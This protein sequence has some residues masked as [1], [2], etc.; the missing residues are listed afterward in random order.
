MSGAVI[1]AVYYQR[2]RRAEVK[3]GVS[4]RRSTAANFSTHDGVIRMTGGALRHRRVLSALSAVAIGALVAAAVAWAW[5]VV[6]R[7][8]EDPLEKVQFTHVEVVQGEVGSSA[9]FSTVAEWTPIQAGVNRA[10]GVVTDEGVAAGTEVTQGSTLY[11]VDLRPIVIGSGLVPMFRDVGANMSGADVKQVQ[12]LLT[13]LGFY[14]GPVTGEAGTG[15]ARSIRAWQKSLRVEQTGVVKAG[16]VIFVQTLPTRV[17]LDT[18]LIFRGAS[19]VAGE[20]VLSVLSASPTF[21]ISVTGAQASMMPAGTRVEVIAPEGDIWEGVTGEQVRDEQAGVVKVRLTGQD[22]SPV[23]RDQCH[24]VPV[25]GQVSLTAR[26]V[27]TETV[28]GLVVPSS[29]LVSGA[30]GQLAVIN[31]QGMRQSVELIAS[32][33]G[34]SVIEGVDEGTRVRVPGEEEK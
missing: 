18:N 26:V 15:T 5:L 24:Q 11:T 21:Q 10:V 31:E 6:T 9:T 2:G 3:W 22:G 7:P 8:T 23:C 34:M 17:V 25:T 20:A 32:A 30:D 12:Q 33:R 27:I 29:A 13:D 1:S 4:I 16:D 19:L 14:S 28:A